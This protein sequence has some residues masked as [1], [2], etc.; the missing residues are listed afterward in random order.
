MAVILL[1][2]NMLD[3]AFTSILINAYGPDVE[4][5][6]FVRSLVLEYGNIGIFIAKAPF[7]AML[8]IAAF[9]VE[10]VSAIPKFITGVAV[11]VY[12]VVVC[13][14]AVLVCLI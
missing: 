4:V 11:S 13:Y 9:T 6:M 2:L 3:I 14:S 12:L 1:V 10:T 8:G 7:L 5:N